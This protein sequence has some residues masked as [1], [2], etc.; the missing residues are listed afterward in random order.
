VKDPGRRSFIFTLRNHLEV[1]PT[2]FGQKQGEDAAFM[3][4]CHAFYFG[5]CEGFRVSPYA[6]SLRSDETYDA[7]DQGAALFNGD[8]GGRFRA[9]RWELW[10]IV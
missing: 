9:A 3:A 5:F 10:E 6:E 8:D 4:R 7:P 1:P 2:R